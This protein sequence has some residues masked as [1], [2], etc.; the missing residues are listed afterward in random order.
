MNKEIYLIK[1]KSSNITFVYHL[2]IRIRNSNIDNMSSSSVFIKKKLLLQSSRSNEC[3]HAIKYKY[4]V[5]LIFLQ[6][7]I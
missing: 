3:K 7:I 1:Y 4:Y 6:N 5:E 2:L